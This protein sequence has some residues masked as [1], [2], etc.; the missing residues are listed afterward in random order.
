MRGFF[1]RVALA[2]MAVLA[3]AGQAQAA[4]ILLLPTAGVVDVGD[5]IFINVWVNEL[6]T[7]HDPDEIVSAYDLDV[8]YDGALVEATD[9]F[10]G[11][12]LG[13]GLFS[14]QFSALTPV[15]DFAEVSFLSDAELDA[16][17][18][19]DVLLATLIFK[20]LAPGT[21][22]FT[23][24]GGTDDVK[25]LANTPLTMN[26]VQNSTFV[27]REPV[28]G[29]PEPATLLFLGVGLAGLVV[30]RHRTRG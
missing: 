14:L 30:G 23:L 29:V 8:T 9:L 25:G 10:F 3:V 21:A 16:D 12:S 19:D 28:T 17:Q 20:A 7:D 4:S 18:G 2:A 6:E 5:S 11:S 24:S 1:G 26:L 13:D 22:V 27:I 15:V